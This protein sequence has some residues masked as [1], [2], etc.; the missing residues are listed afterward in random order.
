MPKRSK[1]AQSL[2]WQR[3]I[4]QQVIYKNKESGRAALGIDSEVDELA[5]FRAEMHIQLNEVP[6]CIAVDIGFINGASLL[7]QGDN[8][9]LALFAK[10]DVDGKFY[11]RAEELESLYRLAKEDW[12]RIDPSLVPELEESLGVTVHKYLAAMKS[13]KDKADNGE[14]LRDLA[15][16][17]PAQEMLSELDKLKRPGRKPDEV[18]RAMKRKHEQTLGDNY[19]DMATEIVKEL[20][21]I[22]QPTK[23]QQEALKKLKLG[24]RKKQSDILSHL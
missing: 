2:Q 22:Q 7:G 11:D 23:A 13:L 19:A 15:R 17:H 14:A 12:R 10:R 21:E 24:D 16:T 5:N 6:W 8:L 1:F 18:L 20:A 4:R 9:R 3:P